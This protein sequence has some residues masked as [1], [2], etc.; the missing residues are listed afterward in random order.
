MSVKGARHLDSAF[1]DHRLA[2]QHVIAD[3][4]PQADRGDGADKDQPP[5]R[6]LAR[7]SAQIGAVFGNKPTATRTGPA[8]DFGCL[9]GWT[10]LHLANS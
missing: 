3:I 2:R 9:L 8:S 6:R 1:A 5:N 4:R 10:W 7:G